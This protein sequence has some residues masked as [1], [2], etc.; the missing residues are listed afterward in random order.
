MTQDHIMV[1]FDVKKL[2]TSIPTDLALDA[3]TQALNDA[4]N[5]TNCSMLKENVL[6]LLKNLP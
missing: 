4:N 6:K 5:L 1:S 2:F 3:L